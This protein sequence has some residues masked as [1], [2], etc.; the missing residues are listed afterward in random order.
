MMSLD[1]VV[2]RTRIESYHDLL[3]V[4]L[5]SPLRS[6]PFSPTLAIVA[7][8]ERVDRWGAKNTLWLYPKSRRAGFADGVLHQRTKCE[9]IARCETFRCEFLC[10]DHLLL[11]SL[12]SPLLVLIRL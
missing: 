2:V 8:K 5:R 4:P 7:I 10:V 11:L 3:R 6:P 12:R 9:Q 1:E